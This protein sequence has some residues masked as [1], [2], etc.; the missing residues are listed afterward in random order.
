MLEVHARAKTRTIDV[1]PQSRY[2]DRSANEN[3]SSVPVYELELWTNRQRQASP[4]HEVSYRACFKPQLPRYFIQ[5]LTKAGDTVYDPFSGRGTTAIEAALLGRNVIANDVNP[6]SEFLTRPR[7]ELPAIADIDERLRRLKYSANAS[8]NIDLSMFFHP[9][10][11]HEI[12]GLRYY[13]V[14]RRRDGGEDSI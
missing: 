11:L 6:L 10:T 1:Q 2:D 3:V 9:Q 14:R 5:Q 4:I 8:A 7:L 13:L 12:A